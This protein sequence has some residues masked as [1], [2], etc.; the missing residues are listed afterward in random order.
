MTPRRA[1]AI[2]TV[3]GVVF[4]VVGIV[5]IVAIPAD[6][7]G[8]LRWGLGIPF[9]IIGVAN[10]VWAPQFSRER[11][12]EDAEFRPLD[13]H[14]QPVVGSVQVQ[15]LALALNRELRDTPHQIETAPDAVRTAY[16]SGGFY[17]PGLR[18]VRQ[19]RWRTTLTATANPTTFVRL[20]QEA[21]NRRGGL[22]SKASVQGGLRMSTSTRITVAG[23]TTV[24]QTV[25][26]GEVS[27]AIEAAMK[28]T[29]V[30]VALPVM[31]W[32]GMTNAALGILIAAGVV[33]AVLIG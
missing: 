32:V 22:W 2:T 17:E 7:P 20:D 10:L 1:Q 28:E 3:L 11:L 6:A 8:L 12:P 19:F 21:D 14:G 29:G 30:T 4:L 5:V 25:S 9:L 31:F 15:R 24:K 27:H 16:N 13:T 26:S 18:S 33:A 23:G